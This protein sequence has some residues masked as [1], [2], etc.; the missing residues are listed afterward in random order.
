MAQIACPVTIDPLWATEFLAIIQVS[1]PA[2]RAAPRSY[3]HTH[4]SPISLPAHPTIQ[5]NRSAARAAPHCHSISHPALHPTLSCPTVAHP[6]CTP[7][8]RS[9][10]VPFPSCAPPIIY[11]Q[12]PKS[13]SINSSSPPFSSCSAKWQTSHRQPCRSYS[14]LWWTCQASGQ[15]PSGWPLLWRGAGREGTESGDWD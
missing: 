5:V 12:S 6:F 14:G 1:Q 9:L 3:S 7:N 4:P 8:P 2:A 11:P 13:L 15:G 10:R